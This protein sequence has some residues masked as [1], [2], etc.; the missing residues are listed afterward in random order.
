MRKILGYLLVC[1]GLLL[2]FFSLISM[3]K[4][5]VD[6]QAVAPV[7]QLADLTLQTAYGPLTVPMQPINQLANLGLFALF[8]LF[9]LAAG[10]KVAQV[11]TNLLK[12]ERIY[13]A[14]LTLNTA[15]APSENTL[16]KL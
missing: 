7:V 3:Y 4:V 16:K 9:V 12:N 2:I 15:N 11:G 8:M 5:F 14:L 1:V 13:E 10:G 6:R